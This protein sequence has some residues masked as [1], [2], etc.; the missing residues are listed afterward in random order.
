M[1]RIQGY[2]W[3]NVCNQFIKFCFKKKKGWYLW[4]VFKDTVESIYAINLYSFALIKC[5]K[6][7]CDQKEGINK[8]IFILPV[9][10][11]EEELCFLV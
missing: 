3:I 6:K 9:I 2:S 5:K 8:D 7:N 1:V 4:F 11:C 10:L